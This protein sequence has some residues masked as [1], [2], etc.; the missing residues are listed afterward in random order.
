MPK[1]KL[2]RPHVN[3]NGSAR[4][5][6]IDQRLLVRRHVWAA[7]EA[8]K[9]MHPHGRDYQGGGDR[10]ADLGVWQARLTALTTMYDDLEAEA[11]DILNDYQRD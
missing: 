6:L 8:L 11:L 5:S 2:M 1:Q 4:Q 10:E 9:Q 7:V 3:M